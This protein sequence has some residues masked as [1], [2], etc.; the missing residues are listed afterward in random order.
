MAS[1]PHVDDFGGVGRRGH[2]AETH[3]EH[4]AE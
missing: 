3:G 1:K 2:C 4:R